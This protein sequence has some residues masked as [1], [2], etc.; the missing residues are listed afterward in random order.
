MNIGM[1]L[2]E[3]RKNAGLT[4]GQAAERLAVTA[5][6]VSSWECGNTTPDIM[7]LPEISELY[8]VSSDW[9]LSGKEPSPEMLEMTQNLSDR[10][11]DENRMFTYIRAFCDARNLFGT[12]K[13]LSFA[14]E[15]HEGQYRKIGHSG[16]KVPY[17]NHP[18]VL[19]CHALAL[20]IGEDDFLA[21]CLLHD[22]CEDCGVLPEELPAN[23][24]VREAVRLLTKPEG[25]RKTSRDN[26]SYFGGLRN[27]RIALMVKILDRCNNISGMAASYSDEK[28]AKY[29]KE[30]VTYVMPLVEIATKEYPEYSNALFLIQYHMES[31]L[32][33]LRHHMKSTMRK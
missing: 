10:I 30:T 14:A 7:K 13:A 12:S 27:N 4:Q 19:A 15:K 6:S 33:A 26:E 11:F 5:Q 3:A 8:G 22:V 23:D 32:E 20:G 18:L 2:A 24:S 29:I 31:V 17:I 28:M 16:K 25:F 9:L 1:R 21:A